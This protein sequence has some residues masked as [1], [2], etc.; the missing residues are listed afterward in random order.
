MIR[1][2]HSPKLS[3]A[4]RAH[5][6]VMKQEARRRRIERLIEREMGERELIVACMEGETYYA[7]SVLHHQ[8]TD[9]ECRELTRVNR[10]RP[11]SRICYNLPTAAYNQNRCARY[12]GCDWR[13]WR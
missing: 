10:H 11:A 1:H 6:L 9:W 2:P 13:H 8:G 5:I 12:G 3:P 7:P 4:D